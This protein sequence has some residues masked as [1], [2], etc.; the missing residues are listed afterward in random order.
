[1][2]C[3]EKQKKKLLHF[4]A[5]PGSG[6]PTDGRRAEEEKQKERRKLQCGGYNPDQDESE[7][8]KL[9][10]GDLTNDLHHLLKTEKCKFNNTKK[11]EK[12]WLLQHLECSVL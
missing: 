5:P 11:G 7:Q 4:L 12:Q 6:D 2:L 10:K 8:I 3:K 9:T 1:M